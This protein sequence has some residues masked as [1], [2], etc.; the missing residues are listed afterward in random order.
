MKI[1][2]LATLTDDQQTLPRKTQFSSVWLATESKTLPQEPP[3]EFHYF[4]KLPKELRFKIYK[5]AHFETEGRGIK[6]AFNHELQLPV[7]LSPAPALLSVDRESRM[8]LLCSKF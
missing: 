5:M 8:E 6:I 1:K 4:P 7:S 3:A 2:H